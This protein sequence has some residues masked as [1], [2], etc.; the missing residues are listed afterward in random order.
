M[1]SSSGELENYTRTILVHFDNQIKQLRENLSEKILSVRDETAYKIE[2]NINDI[3]DVKEQLRD[4]LNKLI[5]QEQDSMILLGDDRHIGTLKRIEES[6]EKYTENTDRRLIKLEESM[7]HQ[8]LQW[9][10][11]FGWASAV[12][13]LSAGIVE[14]FRWIILFKK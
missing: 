9:A 11:L 12:A 8:N 3:A 7:H 5:L 14:L 4:V 6:L 2:K 1:E 13:V 10:K